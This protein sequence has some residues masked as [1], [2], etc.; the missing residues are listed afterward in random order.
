MFIISVEMPFCLI[1]IAVMSLA[2]KIM[3]S[4][5][6]IER[7]LLFT[8]ITALSDLSSVCFGFINVHEWWVDDDLMYFD[9]QYCS[10]SNKRPYFAE[11]GWLRIPCVVA[12]FLVKLCCKMARF[13][14]L[15]IVGAELFIIHDTMT[16]TIYHP[17]NHVECS[18]YFNRLDPLNKTSPFLSPHHQF[19][20][21]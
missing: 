14:R 18:R 20:V 13:L 17:C 12:E 16:N 11:S 8:Y 1:I 7:I 9:S 5:V 10:C 19:L 21:S 6:D 4:Y 3:S 15:K 2:E